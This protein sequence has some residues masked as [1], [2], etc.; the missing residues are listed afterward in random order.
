MFPL[1]PIQLFAS[2]CSLSSRVTSFYCSLSL[3]VSLTLFIPYQEPPSLPFLSQTWHRVHFC[4]GLVSRTKYNGLLLPRAKLRFLLGRNNLSLSY[5][6]ISS[7]NL[8]WKPLELKKKS[9]V[10]KY[11]GNKPMQFLLMNYYLSLSYWNI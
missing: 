4:M 1:R 3:I 7:T 2:V 10:K 6:N 9:T 5:W 11:C 8:E